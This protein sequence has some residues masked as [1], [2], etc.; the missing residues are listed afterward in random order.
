MQGIS[1]LFFIIYGISQIFACY[2]GVD[3]HFG[4]LWAWVVIIASFVLRF[5]LPVTVGAFFGAWQ[6]WHWHW[7]VAAIFAAP[8]LA[9]LVPGMFLSLTE[10]INNRPTK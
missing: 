2:A 3:F 4:S 6:V 9:L 8:G 10:G 5:S 7:I 1:T